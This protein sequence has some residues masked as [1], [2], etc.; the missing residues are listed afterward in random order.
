M[1]A[2]LVTS[3]IASAIV[4][5][6]SMDWHKRVLYVSIP[7]FVLFTIVQTGYIVNHLSKNR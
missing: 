4:M 2:N 7:L 1:L 3:L 6:R 5:K